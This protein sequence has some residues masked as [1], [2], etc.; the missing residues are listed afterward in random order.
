L[1]GRIDD[2][3]WGKMWVWRWVRGAKISAEKEELDVV[4][5]KDEGKEKLEEFKAK[6]VED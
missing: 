4:C 2:N 5:G 3:L 1:G 6:L